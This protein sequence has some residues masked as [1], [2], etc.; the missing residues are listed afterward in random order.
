MSDL[1]TMTPREVVRGLMRGNR[2][3]LKVGYSAENA[4]LAVSE[5]QDL[6]HDELTVLRA[7]AVGFAAGMKREKVNPSD[8]PWHPLVHMAVNDGEVDGLDEWG[9]SPA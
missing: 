2:I 8:L 3:E 7:Y 5:L 9:A 1:A 6:S 4:V